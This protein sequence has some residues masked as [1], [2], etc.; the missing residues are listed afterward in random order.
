ML[1]VGIV[2]ETALGT[3]E[4]ALYN[5]KSSQYHLSIWTGQGCP[6]LSALN[7]DISEG[8]HNPMCIYSEK[9]HGLHKHIH[10]VNFLCH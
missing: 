7:I 4:T 3:Y 9:S 1:S 8:E 10:R 6:N 5:H 2:A